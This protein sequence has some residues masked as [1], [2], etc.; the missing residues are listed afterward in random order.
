MMTLLTVW[1]V[2]VAVIVG[3]LMWAIFTDRWP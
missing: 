3:V 1:L 2:V